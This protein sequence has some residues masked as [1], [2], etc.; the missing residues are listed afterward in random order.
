MAS[1]HGLESRFSYMLYNIYYFMIN[2]IVYAV[3]KLLD[4]RATAKDAMSVIGVLHHISFQHDN[5]DPC[6]Q[7][8]A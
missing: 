3:V 6:Q 2:S 8:Y 5:S 7:I 1:C 4:V